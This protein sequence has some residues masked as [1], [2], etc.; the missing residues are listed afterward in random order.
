V[1]KGIPAAPAAG[2]LV[3]VVAVDRDDVWAVGSTGTRTLIEHWDGVSWK[4]VPSP[5]VG[6]G[7]N[8]L[9]AV[10]AINSNDIWAV[11]AYAGSNDYQTLTLHWNGTQWS[12]VPSPNINAEQNDLR[13]V[14][15]VSS[16]D[17]WAVGLYRD[18]ITDL[19][20]PLALHWNGI[21]WAIVPSPQP[22]P[23]GGAFSAV[24]AIDSTDVWG[25]G[26]FTPSTGIQQPLFANWNGAEWLV[27]STPPFSKDVSLWDAAAITSN[28]VWA[29]GRAGTSLT[30]HWNGSTWTVVPNPQVGD[31]DAFHAVSALSSGDVWA[32][33]E[34]HATNL[35]GLMLQHWDGSEWRVASGLAGAGGSSAYLWDLSATDDAIW[36]IGDNGSTLFSGRMCPI[37]VG[38]AGFSPMSVQIGQGKEVYWHFTESAA[39]SH[40]VTD[41]G[42][43]TLA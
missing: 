32:A 23:N 8:S 14:S 27:V 31:A 37:Q 30:M 34:F 17:V 16:N 11:G 1:W 21:A 20:E 25:I 24:T 29:V 10:H 42:C 43:S 28:D 6:S 22:Q 15:G 36:T 5:S 7:T 12:V 41:G 39:T 38:D 18:A 4:V 13:G 33:G 3:D 9:T 40:S 35:A 19:Y 26:Y 2:V